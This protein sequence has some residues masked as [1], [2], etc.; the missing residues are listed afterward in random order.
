MIS[1]NVPGLFKR[2]TNLVTQ[3]CIDGHVCLAQEICDLIHRYENWSH[4]WDALVRD[5]QRLRLDFQPNDQTFEVAIGARYLGYFAMCN[6]LLAAIDPLRSVKIERRAIY[7]SQTIVQSTNSCSSSG[8]CAPGIHLARQ[9]ARSVM[10]TTSSW[11]DRSSYG[12]YT[13]RSDVFDSL[14]GLLNRSK[15][16]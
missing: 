8:P 11:A 7:A 1:A 14:C 6:R 16:S 2:V 12:L 13:I 15:R 5:K 4:S 9:V 3:E 10:S